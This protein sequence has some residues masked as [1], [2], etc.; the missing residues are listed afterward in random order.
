[1][2]SLKC[3]EH[4]GG[5]ISGF[6]VATAMNIIHCKNKRVILTRGSVSFDCPLK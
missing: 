5:L 2:Y 6:L 1:M 3:P 4:R